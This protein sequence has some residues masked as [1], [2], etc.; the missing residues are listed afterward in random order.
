[1]V[2][3][4]WV[5][6]FAVVFIFLLGGCLQ[7]LKADAE[8]PRITKEELSKMLSNPDVIIIDVRVGAEWKSSDRKIKGAV[9]GDT[10]DIKSW[11]DKYPRDKTLVFYCA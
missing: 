10:E 3:K 6:T 7:N 1:M 4:R 5:A 8:V 11:A 9:R 2:R